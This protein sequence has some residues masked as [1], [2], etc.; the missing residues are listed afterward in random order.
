MSSLPATNGAEARELFKEAYATYQT[1]IWNSSQG[2]DHWK[3]AA[4]NFVHA[5]ELALKTVY[6]KHEQPYRRTHRIDL[7]YRKCP[8]T[9]ADPAPEFT[10]EELE[11]FSMWYL[12]PYWAAKPMT[13][14]HL[15]KC[16][17]ISTE[18]IQWAEK[19]IHNL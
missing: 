8:Q 13:E 9:V 7:L 4:R 14:E 11:E 5:A 6:I 2:R 15:R 1:A 17:H 3:V 19:A 18:I 16:T 12:S 10:L